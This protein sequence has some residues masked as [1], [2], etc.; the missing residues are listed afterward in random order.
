MNDVTLH[1]LLQ[2]ILRGLVILQDSDSTLI[3]E[4]F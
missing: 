1:D 2:K 3:C 4:K